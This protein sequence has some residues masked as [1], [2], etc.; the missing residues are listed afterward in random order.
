MM[1]QRANINFQLPRF[2][3]VFMRFQAVF[4]PWTAFCDDLL[5]QSLYQERLCCP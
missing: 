3:A 2:K 1:G 4:M 5:R